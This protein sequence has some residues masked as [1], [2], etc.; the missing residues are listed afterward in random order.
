MSV[1]ENDLINQFDEI[2]TALICTSRD[3]LGKM[4]VLNIITFYPLQKV[5]FCVFLT[6]IKAKYFVSGF[7]NFFLNQARQGTTNKS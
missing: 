1:Q 5:S 6:P 7:R 4:M 2:N 3:I